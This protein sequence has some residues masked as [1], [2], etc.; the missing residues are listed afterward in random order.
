V[1]EQRRAICRWSRAAVVGV[2]LAAAVLA[3]APAASAGTSGGP[4]TLS[5]TSGGSQTLFTV[6]LPSGAACTDGTEHGYLVDGFL[7]DAFYDLTAS[8]GPTALKWGA[9]GPI[10]DGK[11]VA[12]PLMDEASN[13]YAA[14]ST[15]DERGHLS[16]PPRFLAR[17]Y[18]VDGRNGT[19]P[20][21]PGT[22]LVG[23]T[24]STG[25][26]QT[27]VF[28][29]TRMLVSASTA[30]PNGETWRVAPGA[31]ATTSG[32]SAGLVVGLSLL[33]V[34]IIAVAIVVRRR[35]GPAVGRPS[36]AGG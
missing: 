20:L 11:H 16:T 12:W 31:A 5:P 6:H 24:C 33:A 13:Q 10:G 15:A 32:P 17:V 21:P 22:Y 1:G 25:Q 9:S 2:G 28:F 23:V 19:A 8:S 34:A 7:V 29:S 30:D 4:A 36:R 18:S 27:N 35:H 14:Q 26:R 3:G